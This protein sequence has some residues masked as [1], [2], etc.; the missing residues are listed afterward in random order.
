MHHTTFRPGRARLAVQW[1][2]RRAAACER[3]HPQR[4]IWLAPAA[5]V[6]AAEVRI[7]WSIAAAAMIYRR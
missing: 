7:G 6:A 3:R 1:A 4:T 5:V 2:R